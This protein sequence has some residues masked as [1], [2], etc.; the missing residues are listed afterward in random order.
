MLLELGTR[1]ALKALS[2]QHTQVT[3]E[4][5]KALAGFPNLLTLNFCGTQ[6]EG[7]GLRHLAHL[8]ELQ[9]LLLEAKSEVEL[10]DALPQL[11]RLERLEVH[12]PLTDAGLLRLP[13][14]PNLTV[15][16]I[17]DARITGP[18]LAG[19]TRVPNLA[20]LYFSGAPLQDDS[21]VECLNQLKSLRSVQLIRTG[22]TREG[23]ER[24]R[25]LRPNLNIQWYDPGFS[26]WVKFE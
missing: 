23:C 1:P 9:W 16:E 17:Y 3:D 2:L 19:L 5:M 7:P 4:G 11:T 20:Y 10:L 26:Q 24:L 8:T 13:S 22:V 25:K 18:G 6:I 12:A 15:L 21:F 14:L